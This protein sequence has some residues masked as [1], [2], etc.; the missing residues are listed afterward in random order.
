M[1][2]QVER[3]FNEMIIHT[4]EQQTEEWFNIRIGKF[5]G[6][7]FKTVANGKAATQEKLCIK[8]AAEI[9][10]GQRTTDS[11]KNAHMERGNELEPYAR[12]LFELETGL[13]V[14]E[15]GFCEDESNWFGVSPDGLIGTNS[16]AEFKCKDIHTHAELFLKKDNWKEYKW[17][18][19]GAMMVTGAESWF[20][21]SY[22]PWFPQNKK[23]YIEEV[24][25]DNDLIDQLGAGLL[26]AMQRTEIIIELIKESKK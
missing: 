2:R 15:V 10:T 24:K 1:E 8:K 9:I 3:G 5:T 18:I 20:Y 6:T 23:L 13:E 21:V 14:R 25:R 17:Q 19:Q 11:Y 7:S 26:K 16:G 4:M 12:T 22:N